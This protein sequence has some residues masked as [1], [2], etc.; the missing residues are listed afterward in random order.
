MVRIVTVRS[1][2]LAIGI[3]LTGCDADEEPQ[4]N[5]RPSNGSHDASDASAPTVLDVGATSETSSSPLGRDA[6]A[7]THEGATSH[8]SL[9]SHD[10][11]TFANDSTFDL[12]S[13][14]GEETRQMAALNLPPPNAGLDYQLGGAYRPPEGTEVVSRDRTAAPEPGLYNICYVNGFQVQ[15]GEEDDWEP[16]LLLRDDNGD[17]VIDENW[18]EALLD[19]SSESKR[20]RIADVIGSWI[21]DC[22][23]KGFDA[24][25]VD[26]LDT[27]SR[28]SGSITEDDAVAFV[29]ALAE[30]AHAA[31]LAIAQKNAV[32]LVPRRAEMRTDFVVAEE[33]NTWHEC[34]GYTQGYGAAVLMIEYDRDSFEA[35]CSRYGQE[36]S[37]VLRDRLLVPPRANGYVYDGC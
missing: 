6:A 16:D 21:R 8:G 14:E 13:G 20:R 15:P 33:C 1:L 25:E 2:A 18:D 23:T 19:I 10:G 30:V 4:S 37:L 17:V 35:G 26:N 32:E 9:S 29:G 34:D 11:S 28:S 24:V 7:T 5:P 12:T 3:G 36:Y 27:Y 22:K 31:G